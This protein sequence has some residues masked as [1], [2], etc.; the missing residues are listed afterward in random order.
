[1][2]GVGDQRVCLY[3]YESDESDAGLSVGA[4][5]ASRHLSHLAVGLLG[6]SL[7]KFSPVMLRMS[8]IFQPGLRSGIILNENQFQVVCYGKLPLSLDRFY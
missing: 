2:A 5:G 4:Y 7:G 8:L 1:M 3:K 6:Y